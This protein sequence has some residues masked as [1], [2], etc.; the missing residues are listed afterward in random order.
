M[1]LP[2]WPNSRTV[3]DLTLQSDGLVRHD[4]SGSTIQSGLLAALLRAYPLPCRTN[5]PPPYEGKG[6]PQLTREW[7]RH[8][9]S[10]LRLT[11]GSGGWWHLEPADDIE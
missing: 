2:R 9:D 4:P 10:R 7:L 8:L 6:E 1:T 3:G 5:Y 11:I